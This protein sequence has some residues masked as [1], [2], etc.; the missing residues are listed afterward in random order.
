[1]LQV[2]VGADGVV[3][4]DNCAHENCMFN[5]NI[6]RDVEALKLGKINVIPSN[7]P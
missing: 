2:F 4:L 7:L 3:V 5:Q 6:A 1:M